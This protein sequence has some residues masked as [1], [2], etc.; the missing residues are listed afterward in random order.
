MTATYP[1]TR[2]I[3]QRAAQSLSAS[4]SPPSNTGICR[5]SKLAVTLF[6][7]NRFQIETNAWGE[8]E[9]GRTGCEPLLP[10]I[11]KEERVGERRPFG[12]GT[13][14]SG[15]LPARASRGEREPGFDSQIAISLISI[16]YWN[17]P[18][19]AFAARSNAP[20]ASAPLLA[21][22]KHFLAHKHDRTTAL[23]RS[24]SC[25][26]VSFD[27]FDPKAQ[28]ALE[29][30]DASKESAAPRREPLRLTVAR[31]H[32][33][34]SSASR[35]RPSTPSRCRRAWSSPAR[36]GPRRNPPPSEDR[37]SS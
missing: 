15:S 14:L 29:P 18:N 30:S 12:L 33:R 20:V 11:H 17:K 8:P 22:L 26:V 10:L 32:R 25:P 6:I 24:A 3:S 36:R 7:P 16:A 4:G 5:T 37:P 21:S 19:G 34:L 28:Y 1:S 31:G 35:L 9:I 23:K 2:L 13:P 27:Q